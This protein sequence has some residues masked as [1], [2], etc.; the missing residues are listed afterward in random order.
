MHKMPL[1]LPPMTWNRNLSEEEIFNLTLNTSNVNETDTFITLL[2]EA[3]LSYRSDCLQ[4]AEDMYK[5][6]K[7]C[8][9]GQRNTPTHT[10]G[11]CIVDAIILKVPS[12]SAVLVWA[13]K[14][15]GD[16]NY[17]SGSFE[18]ASRDYEIFL[19]A[20]KKGNPEV[21]VCC[22]VYGRLTICMYMTRQQIKSLK[23]LHEYENCR[24]KLSSEILRD[25]VY[26]ELDENIKGFE[27]LLANIENVV[28]TISESLY[29][30]TP[31]NGFSESREI[32]LA[33][34]ACDYRDNAI[35]ANSTIP[36]GAVLF[37]EEQFWSP[38]KIPFLRC[39]CCGRYTSLF[40]TC[41]DCRYKCYCSL[42]C[43][44]KDKPFHQFECEGY[45]QLSLIFL[46]AGHIFR[47]FVRILFLLKDNVFHRKIFQKLKTGGEVLNIIH[48]ILSDKVLYGTRYLGL[49][50]NKPSYGNLS[51]VQY[52]TLITT[53][54]RLT[55]FIEKKTNI[56][57][58]F[59]NKLSISNKQKMIVVGSLLMRLH[60]N[61][62]LNSFDVEYVGYLRS[63]S[64]CD[65]EQP[66]VPKYISPIR[67]GP[68]EDICE[69]YNIDVER[70]IH[71]RND[72]IMK[73]ERPTS[74]ASSALLNWH[75]TKNC[76]PISSL[77]SIFKDAIVK[78]YLT[79][80]NQL[81]EEC[82][83]DSEKI[84]DYIAKTM[85]NDESRFEL[86]KGCAYLFHK[87]FV[88]YFL[89]M[90]E[91]YPNIS[92]MAT[93]YCPTM[94][95][96]KH[97]C[98]PN[99]QVMVLDNGV[100]IGK[101][102]RDINENEELNIAFKANYL[103]H[104]R[105]E[106]E[107]FL[108]TF[109]TKC[110]CTCCQLPEVGETT[111][112]GLGIK[113]DKCKD[114]VITLAHKSCSKCQ[115]S[116]SDLLAKYCS[117]IHLIENEL[118]AAVESNTKENKEREIYVLQTILLRQAKEYFMPQ[119]EVF[120][121]IELQYAHF[122]ALKNF[123]QQSYKLLMKVKERILKYYPERSIWFTFYPFILETIKVILHYN[124]EKRYRTLSKHCLLDLCR[125][126]IYIIKGQKELYEFYEKFDYEGLSLLEEL[127]TFFIWKKQII[128]DDVFTKF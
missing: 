127:K 101:S 32:P 19:E 87:F 29:F 65:G 15:R 14:V 45:M 46:D 123:A 118:K 34:A 99:V 79:D 74:R 83:Q 70:D 89:Q 107:R 22:Q 31:Y 108:R 38:V 85:N 81:D 63:V 61:I 13:L 75:H 6:A 9:M 51:N 17:Q 23:Y 7:A 59:L 120:L 12:D 40:Y 122:L 91:F 80:I 112:I 100:V 110:N 72:D 25:Q 47:L 82:V 42:I 48:D 55:I 41:L 98:L 119:N 58:T 93:I 78:Q 2:D 84:N 16:F 43:I 77:L 104:A 26:A 105:P 53:A 102:L 115:I 113:C 39:E 62:L 30:V 95:K 124:L 24:V 126:G 35:Y 11:M 54:F 128:C 10:K 116:Y 36:K 125:L 103:V 49:I 20:C 73:C 69:F 90:F 66:D 96:F 68:V 71:K 109:N 60:A 52:S 76:S 111:N 56:L 86:V 114:L 1:K 94:T 106:R 64:L 27:L 4:I 117:T 50:R 5:E 97:S 3:T 44:E 92:E 28:P 37:V 88:G 18:Y 21:G 121:N 57:E 8:L 67:D 33:S